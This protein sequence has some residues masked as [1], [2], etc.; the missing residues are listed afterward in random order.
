MG[1]DGKNARAIDFIEGLGF[2]GA[3]LSTSDGIEGSALGVR[4]LIKTPGKTL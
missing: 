3:G 1:V 4:S 2:D